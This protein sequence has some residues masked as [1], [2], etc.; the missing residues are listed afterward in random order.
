[1]ADP[2]DRAEAPQTEPQGDRRS[3]ILRATAA[4][5]RFWWEFLIG[6]TPE[7]FVGGVAVVGLIALLCLDHRAKTAAAFAL[8]VLVIA[9]LGLSVRRAVRQR[10]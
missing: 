5:G 3:P 1:M 9:L 6:D 7:L 10:T 2:A 4:F 8:P